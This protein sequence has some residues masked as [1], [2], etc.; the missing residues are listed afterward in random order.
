MN[1]PIRILFVDHVDSFSENLIAAF[2]ARGCIVDRLLSL[3]ADENPHPVLPADVQKLWAQKSFDALVLSPGPLR[4]ECY[5]LSLQLLNEWPCD[6]P[7]LG[8]CLGHQMLLSRNSLTL[9]LVSECPVH[10]R[11]ERLEYV[12]ASS[13]LAGFVDGGFATFY[14]SWAV[15]R[16]QLTHPQAVKAPAWRLLSA[17]GPFVALAEHT[18]CPWVGVQYHPESFATERG[19]VLLDAFVALL[20][21][22]AID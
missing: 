15:T 19:A 7:V 20:Q 3:P 6:R 22:R 11:R 9:C 12:A 18:A 4:P 21:G 13:W 8:V 2:C 16:N 17:N 5:P 10:G 1:S 14:N